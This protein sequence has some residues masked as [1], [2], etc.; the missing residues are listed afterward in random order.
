P[1]GALPPGRELSVGVALRPR[2]SASLHNY[3]SAVGRVGSPVYHHYLTAAAFAVEFAPSTATVRSVEQALRASH[4]EVGHVTENRLII[5]VRGSASALER[6]FH[7]RLLA[8]RERGGALGWETSGAPR[9]ARQVASS[10]SAIVGLDNVLAPHA[11]SFSVHK[12]QAAGGG[13]LPASP[14]MVAG[15]PSACS[16]ALSQAK[17]QGGWTEDQIAQAYGLDR[18]YAEGGL[19]AGQTI[20]LL[21]LEP[22]QRSD[23]ATFDRCFF[24]TSHTSQVSAVHVDGFN[25]VGP[26]SGESLLDLEVVSALAPKAAI[27]VYET[28]NTSYGSID[29]YDE[30]VSS[31]S[32]N[33]IST[34]WGECETAIQLA[35]PGTQQVESYLFEEAAAQ[36]QTVFA[37]AGDTGS[38]DCAGTQFA[39]NKAEPPYLS[40]D[41][42][43]SQPDVIAVGGTSLLSDVQPLASTAE[44]AWNDGASGGGGGGGISGSWPSPAWQADSG[45]PGISNPSGRL[46][47]D[48]AAAADE[49]H[50]M[51]IYMSGSGPDG[52]SS[53]YLENWQTIGGTSGAAPIWAAIVADIAS[54][55][56]VCPGLPSRS[57]G[58]DLGFVA[59][60]LYAV[61]SAD[62]GLAFHDVALGNNDV[63][64]LGL[65][66]SA[67]PGFNLAAGL[68]SPIVTNPS[69]QSGLARLLCSAAA[70][71]LSGLANPVVTGISPSGEG[72]TTGGNTVSISGRGFAP[73]ASAKITVSFGPAT[74]T[75]QS[76][77]PT[78]VTVIVPA[79][80]LAP[81]SAPND[82]AGSVGVAVTV[83]D[84][85]GSSTSPTSL[86]TQY[87]YVDEQPAGAL[88]PSVSGIG[89]PG[90]NLSGGNHVAI[91]GSGFSSASVE[92]VTFGGALAESFSVVNTGEIKAVVPPESS[93]TQCATGNDFEPTT[94]CQVE[95]EV[96][97]SSGTSVID[98]ILP[99]ENGA[100]AFGPQ[101]II[102]PTSGFE[103]A[104]ASTEYDYAPTPRITSITPNPTQPSGRLPVVINGSG[105][106]L[107]T[108]EW[109]NFGPAASV[110]SEQL[111]ILSVS[112]NEITIRPPIASSSDGNPTPLPGGV[113][114]ATA[115]GA[116]N[117]APF[118]YA[119]V[120]ELDR[121]SRPGGP[122]RGGT[123]I[124]LEGRGLGD[125]TSVSFLGELGGTGSTTVGTSSIHRETPTTLDVVSPAH[126][127]GPVAVVACTVAGCARSR[128]AV[129]TFVFYP[130]SGETLSGIEPAHGG[131][132]GGTV[133]TLFGKNV[134]S[135]TAVEF[136][137]RSSKAFVPSLTYAANDPDVVSVVSP[138]GP[139]RKV[140]EVAAILPG[141]GRRIVATRRF[142][143]QPSVPSAPVGAIVSNSPAGRTLSWQPPESDGGSSLTGYV[144][145]AMTNGA[146]PRLFNLAASAR[147]F[148]LTRLSPG[149]TYD[150]AIAAKN[151]AFGRG[152]VVTTSVTIPA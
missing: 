130:S 94:V 38:D 134:A 115:A 145:V 98:P 53:S 32:A 3:I 112:P 121:L 63:F 65:G 99:P 46:V 60:E 128:R 101:G 42:P 133:V 131:A 111:R 14:P 58:A 11:L 88:T 74:A 149:H 36:G 7:T 107:V 140:V 70:G 120:P 109:V 75:V 31:D 76:V 4:L 72:P 103:S 87:E 113:S 151:A 5:P 110:A 143:Y 81:A 102:V 82:A 97:T 105:F 83:R 50:G 20:D 35:A 91:F 86:A 137:S 52:Q 41:D 139:A 28:P 138:P 49:Q 150:L 40:V 62:Y 146:A 78:S 21:E 9:L 90:G 24:G 96:T 104:P 12:G 148:V 116:S 61:A 13:D 89:P 27:D 84:A 18:L 71:R 144:V 126:A 68:G 47:P 44:H 122:T 26:G 152:V 19:G 69:G 129:D 106:S 77:S 43:A 30:M 127:A 57:G 55:K 141:V 25:F 29:A 132:D 22:Y 15:A 73:S 1:L 108:F 51:T 33:V 79:S 100:V 10:V 119:G 136:G 37:A 23:L 54:S 17:S 125:V 95:V 48:V 135:A 45:V 80:P 2:N 118:S 56:T 6:A 34:S 124:E 85:A 93:A 59:P 114:I 142:R 39:S 67:T 92:K 8:Y 123:S 66:Y 147:S 64:G 16:A 117:V